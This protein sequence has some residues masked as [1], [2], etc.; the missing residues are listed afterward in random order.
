VSVLQSQGNRTGFLPSGY[1]LTKR[2]HISDVLLPVSL[3]LWA[4][5]VSRTDT[6]VLGPYGLL[7]NVPLIFYAAIALLIVSVTTELTRHELSRW[8][9]SAHAAA[10]VVMLYGT[11]PIVYSEGRYSWLYK[12]VGVVQYMSVHGQVNQRIDIYQSWPGFFAFAAW[13]DKVAGVASPLAYA[14]WAQLVVELAVLP[15]LYLIYE[16]L[17]LPTRQRWVALL[18]YSS[19]N[20]IGQDYFSPQAIG[21]ILSLGIMAMAMRWMYAGNSSGRYV[22]AGQHGQGSLRRYSD[23][24]LSQETGQ[25]TLFF[26]ALVLVYAALTYT[27]ELSP[28]MVVVQLGLLAMVSLFRP[29]WLPLALGAVAV[30]YFIPRFSYVNSHWGLI[31]SIGRFFSNIAPPSLAE[32]ANG[33]PANQLL[34]QHCADALSVLIWTLSLVGV[35]LRRRSRRTVAALALLAYSP[36][37]VLMAGGYG[38]EGILRVF[39][40]SLP[41]SAALAAAV[42][43]PTPSLPRLPASS[44]RDHQEAGASRRIRWPHAEALR[45]PIA[46]GVII[47]LFLIA[48]FGGDKTN[49]M[50]KSEVTTVTSFQQTAPAGSVLAAIDNA[51][52]SDTAR[53]NLF[54][55]APVFGQGGAWG[56]K[57]PPSDIATFLADEADRCS[58]GSQPTYLMI[59]TAMRDY[60]QAYGTPAS[61]FTVLQTSLARSKIWKL[62]VNRSGTLIY[63]L[64]P[65]TFP[66]GFRDTGPVPA[67]T[68]P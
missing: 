56:I 43:T 29:R 18:I 32:S 46:F 63:E 57:Q 13:F 3:I 17:S 27:H 9:M 16:A 20:W 30:I 47:T 50:S 36:V 45:V 38:D 35:W 37:I 21:T 51:P 10:L 24:Q 41:W 52:L 11:A 61:Y 26:V 60:G 62:I 55:V 2:W 14:K 33:I 65:G 8:R 44:R 1:A 31:S 12:T 58:L 42:V 40:F 5:A 25:L 7:S 19:A 64:P 34:V 49:V 39:L 68:V 53:Y 23:Q 28:Y 59:T 54:P 67:Y 6:T 66:P 15:L 22:A 48:F 4:V